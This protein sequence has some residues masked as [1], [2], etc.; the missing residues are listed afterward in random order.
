ML[1]CGTL[2]VSAVSL[3]L[4]MDSVWVVTYCGEREDIRLHHY[5]ARNVG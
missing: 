3:I 4:G 1:D 5:L 2:P